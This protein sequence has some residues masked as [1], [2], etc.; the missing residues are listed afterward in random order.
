MQHIL[1]TVN[2]KRKYSSGNYLQE[3][4]YYGI[5][6]LSNYILSLHNTKIYDPILW[7]FVGKNINIQMSRHLV[8]FF[9]WQW[10]NSGSLQLRA[11]LMV[12]K[13]DHATIPSKISRDL[14]QKSVFEVTL[15]NFSHLFFFSVFVEFY[16]SGRQ[17]TH[18]WSI[19][20]LIWYVD[21]R[22]QC[23]CAAR[24]A[25]LHFRTLLLFCGFTNKDLQDTYKGLKQA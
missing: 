18:V 10:Q 7:D 19:L 25:R 24:S 14:D 9:N 8:C 15:Y 16:G 6:H 23:Y 20:I 5:I 2:W 21:G 11:E 3:R 13:L 4:C 17:S 12:L 22:R 1:K